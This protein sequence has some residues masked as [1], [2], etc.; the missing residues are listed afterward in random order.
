MNWLPN[1]MAFFSCF[2]C[3]ATGFA[4]AVLIIGNIFYADLSAKADSNKELKNALNS[5]ITQQQNFVFH[6]GSNDTI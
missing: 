6:G 1:S 4:F 3:F 2:K 5:C